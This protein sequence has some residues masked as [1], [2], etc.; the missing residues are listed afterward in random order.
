MEQA[1]LNE[2][3]DIHLLQS[4]AD[5]IVKVFCSSCVT[6]CGLGP[7]VIRPVA[8]TGPSGK[9]HR[10][11]VWEGIDDTSHPMLYLFYRVTDLAGFRTL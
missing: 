3:L 8:D 10:T 6:V 7:Q 1:I 4:R 11:S 9:L 5:V 2:K